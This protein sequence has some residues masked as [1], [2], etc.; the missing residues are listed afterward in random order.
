MDEW[1]IH[2]QARI[3]DLIEELKKLEP[4]QKKSLV[5]MGQ[6]PVCTYMK[7]TYSVTSKSPEEGCFNKDKSIECIATESCLEYCSIRNNA[8]TTSKTKIRLLEE[9]KNTYRSKK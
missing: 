8:R 2:A 5:W 6:C 9:L 7:E 3:T 4:L 1:K